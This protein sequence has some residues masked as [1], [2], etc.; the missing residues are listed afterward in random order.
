MW[1]WIFNFFSWIPHH[2]L[3]NKEGWAIWWGQGPQGLHSFLVLLPPNYTWHYGGWKMFVVNYDI[4][5]PLYFQDDF[6]AYVFFICII[7]VSYS[8]LCIY[9]YIFL[10]NFREDS[11]GC[12]WHVWHLRLFTFKGRRWTFL[13]FKQQ[14]NCTC[15]YIF[16]L[17][18]VLYT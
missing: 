13:Y 10:S 7:Y 14:F 18:L 11:F 2:V 15:I 5:V 1:R 17:H 8:N 16:Y 4:K 3:L 12:M 6:I 9:L